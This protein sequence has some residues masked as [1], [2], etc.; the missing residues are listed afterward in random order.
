M[1]L[2]TQGQPA[3]AAAT[4]SATPCSCCCCCC[5]HHPVHCSWEYSCCHVAEGVAHKDDQL[6]GPRIDG[7]PAAVSAQ[8]L[9]STAVEHMQAGKLAQVPFVVVRFGSH[10]QQLTLLETSVYG[11]SRRTSC[12][13]YFYAGLTCNVR[14]VNHH[15]SSSAH[16]EV[17]TWQ[18]CRPD[19]DQ[20]GSSIKHESTPAA[21]VQWHRSQ[22]AS[23]C[24]C[25]PH[26]PGD[27]S[28]HVQG[29]LAYTC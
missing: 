22:S 6:I 13:A 2:E 11:S 25:E 23:P 14:V 5:R 24:Q 20:L 3:A 21:Q 12:E 26:N 4:A 7:Q 18:K 10:R 8:D 9:L 28:T 1:K 27:H 15:C 19:P 29:L 16:Q 17:C